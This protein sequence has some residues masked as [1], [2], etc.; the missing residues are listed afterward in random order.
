ME[1][2][3]WIESIHKSVREMNKD[4]QKLYTNHNEHQTLDHLNREVM[5]LDRKLQKFSQSNPITTKETYTPNASTNMQEVGDNRTFTVEELVLFDGKNGNP[6]YVA[7]NGVVYDVTNS[8]AWAAATHFG[9]CAGKDLSEEFNA[10]HE[11]QNILDKL[12]VVGF[13][14]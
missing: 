5:I 14:S 9:L 3:L 11:G 12:P 2:D 1:F 8:A 6:A 10:C 13:L 7:V 4:I